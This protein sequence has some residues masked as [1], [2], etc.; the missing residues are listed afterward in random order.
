MDAPVDRSGAGAGALRAVVG[1][2]PRA[3][4]ARLLAEIDG[5]VAAAGR[6]PAALARPLRVLVPSHSL[7][8]HLSVRLARRAGRPILGVAVRTLHAA[9]SAILARAGEPLPRGE[10]LLELAVLRAAR[11]EPE[12]AP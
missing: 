10:E 7:A 1:A 12:L 6:D 2:G 3:L 9:A 11:R 5:H 4:E 8:Q